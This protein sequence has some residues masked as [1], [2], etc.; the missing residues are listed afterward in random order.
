MKRAIDICPGIC[1]HFNLTDIE[2]YAFGI[3]RAGGFAAK[4]VADD[5]CGQTFVGDHARFDDVAKI[6]EL[7][8]ESARIPVS[9]LLLT[10][11]HALTTPASALFFTV[12]YDVL[13][14]LRPC[15]P[16]HDRTGHLA[17]FPA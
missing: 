5:R 17:E 1:D 11:I 3:D 7:L 8:H 12:S 13:Q 14:V 10:A 2:L 4:V 9:A 16:A 6:D 15:D